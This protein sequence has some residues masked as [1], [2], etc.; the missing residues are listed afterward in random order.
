M[1]VAAGMYYFAHENETT[2]L[3][4]IIFIHGAG[5]AHLSWPPDM[6]RLPG[7]NIYA[8]DLPGHGKSDGFGEQTIAAY[9]GHILSWMEAENHYR[10]VM[11]GHSMGAAI[12]MHIA[13]IHPARVAGLGLFGFGSPLEVAPEIIENLSNSVMVSAALNQIKALSFGPNASPRL[14]EL[15]YKRLKE[16]RPSVLRG[17][18]LA[19]ARFDPDAISARVEQP[20]LIIAGAHDQMMPLRYAQLLSKK[21]KRT[22]LH[23]IP[24]AGHLLMLETPQEVLTPLK[25]F[26][27][28]HEFFL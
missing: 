2:T 17:D 15:V 19:C 22:E 25:N 21:I 9:A 23:V 11:V 1:P 27:E 12:A 24:D 6:R 3:P 26:L 20:T 18:F 28:K 14:L 8:L 5:G 13:A 10:A 7:Y 4:P 16:I